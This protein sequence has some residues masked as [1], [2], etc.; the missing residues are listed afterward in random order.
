MGNESIAVEAWS[1]FDY[2]VEP[3][4][5][6]LAGERRKIRAVERRWRTPGQI[7]FVV[8]SEQD[9]V[10]ELIYDPVHDVWSWQSL[11]VQ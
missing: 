10:L 3:L 9:E 8:R 11:P 2:A 1:S 7:H 4:A 6:T 5:F